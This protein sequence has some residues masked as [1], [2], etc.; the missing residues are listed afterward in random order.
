LQQAQDRAAYRPVHVAVPLF[1][2]P[3]VRQ[4]PTTEGTF[5][6]TDLEL[7]GS[8]APAV[9]EYEAA[10]RKSFGSRAQLNYIG[11][12]G[13]IGAKAFVDALRRIGPRVDRE[14]LISA[15]EKTDGQGGF[16]FAAPLRFGPYA[17]DSRD[18][19]RCLKITKVVQ[20]KAVPVTDWRCDNQP[21]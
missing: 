19:N 10:V 6:A 1:V 5:V 3:T 12:Q 16:G 4:G 20:G 9:K 8:S 13:W 2:D 7:P 11:V 15:V 17:A 18:I 21:F 14:A